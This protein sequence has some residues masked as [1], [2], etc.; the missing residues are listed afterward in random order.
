MF[1]RTGLKFCG[2]PGASDATKE[3]MPLK[4]PKPVATA[5]LLAMATSCDKIHQVIVAAGQIPGTPVNN[6]K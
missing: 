1:A 5:R 4:A 3:D 6:Q 2:T